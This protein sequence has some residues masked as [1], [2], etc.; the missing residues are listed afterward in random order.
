MNA[1]SDAAVLAR[2]GAHRH[3][4]PGHVRV[5]HRVHRVHH[6][7]RHHLLQMYPIAEHLRQGGIELGR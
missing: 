4:P 7:V 5:D 3:A 2:L 6:Q 1:D